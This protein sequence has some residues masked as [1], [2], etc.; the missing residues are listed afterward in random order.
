VQN[1]RAFR[2]GPQDCDETIPPNKPFRD[3]AWGLA[4]QGI[5]V[6]RYEKRT[7]VYAA[8]LGSQRETLTVKE[9]VIDDALCVCLFA[10]VAPSREGNSG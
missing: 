3:L 9:E 6:L 8:S 1:T 2:S 7:N 10:F 5:A 4:S